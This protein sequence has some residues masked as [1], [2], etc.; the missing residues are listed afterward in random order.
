MDF[1]KQNDQRLNMDDFRKYA[2]GHLGLNSQT[3]DDV[4]KAESQYLKSIPFIVGKSGAKN[5]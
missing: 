3:L 5:V 4:I 2:V 1:E